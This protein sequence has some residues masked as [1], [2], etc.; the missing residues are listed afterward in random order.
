MIAVR[1]HKLQ[2]MFGASAGLYDGAKNIVA[3]TAAAQLQVQPGGGIFAV[4][5]FA[6]WCGHCQA[7]SPTWKSVA[8]AACAAPALRIG[9]V[10]CVAYPNI[11]SQFQIQ[12]YP[13]I[14]LFGSGA[15]ANGVSLVGCPH[16]CRNVREIIHDILRTS[17]RLP[18]VP[19]LPL[20]DS[21]ISNSSRSVCSKAAPVSAN[22]GSSPSASAVG[23]STA[24]LLR[25]GEAPDELA[26]HPRPMED[27]TSA[28][29]YSFQHEL[30]AVPAP[31][32]SARRAALDAWLS[33]LEDAMPGA[34]NRAALG[35]IRTRVA[36]SVSESRQ[37]L[38]A[39]GSLPKPWLPTGGVARA[40]SS[41]E[42]RACQGWSA[43]SRGYPCALWSLF[44]TLLA[45]A[46]DPAVA[47]LA[48]EGYVEHFFGCA[49][50]S[51][52]FLQMARAGI[53][54]G[55]GGRQGGAATSDLAAP[56]ARTGTVSASDRAPSDRAPDGV[57][58]PAASSSGTASLWL[59]RAHNAVNLRLNGT[60]VEAVRNLGLPK[61]QWP[62]AATCPACHSGKAS[63][64]TW[65][66][67]AVAA[68]LG[69]TYCQP[70]LSLCALPVQQQSE[71]DNRGSPR[72][73]ITALS[74]SAALMTIAGLP[75]WLAAL[76]S[77]TLLLAVCGWARRVCAGGTRARG[78]RPW[79]RQY[80]R[81]AMRRFRAVNE[82]GTPRGPGSGYQGLPPME[83][84]SDE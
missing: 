58:A 77:A 62:D 2:A 80:E 71:A 22:T 63:G 73:G 59:W 78:G 61:V 79:G 11:C 43:A 34:L 39:L 41:V 29:A 55:S 52:H 6:P 32:G 4:E 19:A 9:V 48:I 10:D 74:D 14:R 21:L 13:S 56:G 81:S 15:R 75:P 47:L 45:H 57:H 25:V 72:V 36:P 33:L 68:F 31:A 1:Q 26:W 53:H 5:F 40:A 3:V 67:V 65:D 76:A 16:G 12:S 35:R 23:S 69:S 64:G 54:T 18:A 27:L 70:K 60:G 66:E 42:W 44:H 49:A 83:N 20:A 8:N 30:F 24:K 28:I 7:F 46:A 51:A 37:W 84:L 17:E 50:C 38:A 82:V